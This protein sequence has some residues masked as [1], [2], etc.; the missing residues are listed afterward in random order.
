MTLSEL[1]GSLR[2]DWAEP[3]NRSYAPKCTLLVF[4]V[5][6]YACAERRRWAVRLAWRVMDRLYVRL[7]M[8]AEL[9]PTIHVGSPLKLPHGGRGVIIHPDTSIEG[10]CMIFH[11]V[12]FAGTVD[13]APTVERDVTIGVNA[14]VIGAVR[15]G[16]GARVG[17]NAVVTHDV[18]PGATAVGVPARVL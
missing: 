13:G 9:P 18:P 10:N 17:A 12:T 1:V 7:L 15:V 14:C 3:A 16:V 8:G 2:A 4:R 6:Q 5:G 11:R